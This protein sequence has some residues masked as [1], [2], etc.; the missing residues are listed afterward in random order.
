[1]Q[2]LLSLKAKYMQQTGQDYKSGVPPST[3]PVTAQSSPPQHSTSSSQ[4]Q[5]SS[6]PQAQALFAD[7]AQQ[8][9]QVRQ[10]KAEKAPKVRNVY[11]AAPFQQYVIVKRVLFIAHVI[12][13]NFFRSKWIKQ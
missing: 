9:E 2:Q 1:M 4:P 12:V 13:I 6:S 11:S 7:I 5:S 10:L 3:G 8:G